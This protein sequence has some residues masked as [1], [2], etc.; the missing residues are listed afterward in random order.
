M[1]QGIEA[2]TES[3]AVSTAQV[4]LRSLA[5]E[6]RLWLGLSGIAL[7]AAVFLLHQLMAWPPHEDETLALFVGRDSL[8][9]VIEH[10][11]QERGGA[12]LHFLLAWTVAHLGFGLGGLRLRVSPVRGR[13]PPA[14]GAARAAAGRT[15]SRARR[16]RPRRPELALSL[17]R[18]LRPDVQRLPLLLPRLLARPA[19]GARAGRSRSLGALG[20]DRAARR[21]RRTRTRCCCWPGRARTSSSPPATASRRRSSQA[22]R[23]SSSA[24]R[25]GSRISCSSNA[26]RSASAAAVRSS[27]DPRRLRVTCGARSAT[28]RPAGGPSRSQSSPRRSSASSACAGRRARSSSARSASPRPLSCS[29]DSAAPPRPSP[30]ISSSSPRCS[31]SR[32]PR[33]SSVSAD[34]R[35]SWRSAPSRCSSRSRSP[36]PGSARPRSSS[37]SR[38]PD[39]RHGPRPRSGS[40]RRA[41]TTTCSSATSRCTSG[42]GSGIGR[43]RRPSCRGPIP[44]SRCARSS[45]PS[46]LGRGVWVL[47]ASERNNLRPALEVERRL[48][49]PADAFEARVFGPF[50]VLR[51]REPTITP[52]AYLY[53]GARALL[54]GQ[55][56]G[57]GDADVNIRTVVLAARD[58][59][60]YGPSL[61]SRSSN[62][63]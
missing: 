54:V 37:G 23:C 40:R 15:T 50:L 63:R 53:Y 27:A 36:G 44:G 46:P 3:T 28:R 31:P 11:T 16:H 45:G 55:S 8:P 52:E 47:D 10:V 32:S 21:S 17:P 6:S 29:R 57:I 13:E 4:S 18:R 38:T 60:G 30:G 33:R 58:L 2:R 34:A 48:P 22:S 12:P 56:L 42:R 51:T 26:S 7:A 9:A 41:A 61:R 1:T 25:S 20:G 14:R 19:A 43:C 49:D 24:S 39:R 5:A 62:S 35:R 59:R